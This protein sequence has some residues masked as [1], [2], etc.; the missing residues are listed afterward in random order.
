MKMGLLNVYQEWK[1]SRYQ[2]HVSNMREQDKCPD[3]YGRGYHIFP[4]TEFVYNVTPYDCQGCDG[5]GTFEQWT[6]LNETT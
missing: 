5:T 6:N 1:D 4:A 3:C 2:K